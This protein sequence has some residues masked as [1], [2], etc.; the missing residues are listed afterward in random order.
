VVDVL[1][2]RFGNPQ[3]II[4]AHY[5]SLSHLPA[6]INQTVSLKQC[7]DTIEQHLRSLEAI[8]EDV[9][10]RHFVALITEKLPQKVLYQ[11]YMMKGDGLCQSCA[12]YW[13]GT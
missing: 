1:K 6:A 7:F 11:L 2:R 3:L 4:D 9:N 12:T 10:H 13:E 8:G 5:H